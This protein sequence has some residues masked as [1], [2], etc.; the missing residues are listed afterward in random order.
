MFLLD[1]QQVTFL[2][3]LLDIVI[4]LDESCQVVHCLLLLKINSYEI[5]FNN[6][7]NKNN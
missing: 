5:S 1:K 3:E 4:S 7:L 6:E 2:V